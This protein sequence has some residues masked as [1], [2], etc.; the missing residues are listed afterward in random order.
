MHA[1]HLFLMAALT[2]AVSAMPVSDVADPISLLD[3]PFIFRNEKGEVVGQRV[4]L[5][6]S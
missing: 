4:S 2:T 5:L 3:S 6:D 1:R